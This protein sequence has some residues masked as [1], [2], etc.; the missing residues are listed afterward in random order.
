[1]LQDWWIDGD[2]LNASLV[3]QVEKTL[4]PIETSKQVNHKENVFFSIS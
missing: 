4:I 3:H 1:M 2:I